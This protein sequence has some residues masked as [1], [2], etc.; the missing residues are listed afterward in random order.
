MWKQEKLE[1]QLEAVRLI[2]DKVVVSGGLAWHLMSPYHEEN[3]F[4]HDHKD[5]DL[6]VE[7]EKANE[8][9]SIFK[10]NGFNRHWT[11]YDGKTP[12]FKRYGKTEMQSEKRVKVLIDLFIERGIPFIEVPYEGSSF[13]VVEPKTLLSYYK[14]PLQSSKCTAVKAASILVARGIDPVGRSE[15]IGKEIAKP[16]PEAWGQVEKE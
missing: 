13:Y 9:I 15:L 2:K 8:V 11:K 10:A 14:G 4:I 16:K 12:G 1:A 3:K 7:P 6:F 5:V